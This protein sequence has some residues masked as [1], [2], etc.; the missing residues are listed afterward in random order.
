MAGLLDG[1]RVVELTQ[2]IQGP[3]CGVVLG[4]LGADVIK[5]EPKTGD[6]ARG[7]MKIVGVDAGL[8]GRNYFFENNNRNKRSKDT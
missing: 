8:K 3:I 2:F 1:I 6:P 4:D 7:F 5:V